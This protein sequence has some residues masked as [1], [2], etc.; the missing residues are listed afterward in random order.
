MIAATV[1]VLDACVL[2]SFA[3]VHRFD[4]LRGL[5]GVEFL[6]TEHVLKEITDEEQKLEVELQIRSGLIRIHKLINS[7]A[8]Q[9]FFEMR[10]YIG[11]GEASCIVLAKENNWIVG[12]DDKRKVPRIISEHLG[13]E[14]LITTKQILQ[15]AIDQKVI[16]DTEAEGFQVELKQISRMKIA[17]KFAEEL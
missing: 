3:Q 2:I 1:I 12:S 4:I 13:K 11:P 10:K 7:D 8:M 6:T 16:D 17:M 14:T 9:M 5:G 15:M